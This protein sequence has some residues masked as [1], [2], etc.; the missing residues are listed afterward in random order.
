MTEVITT[1]DKL[2]AP[3]RALGG[4][5][6]WLPERGGIPRVVKVDPGRQMA[7]TGWIGLR[8]NGAYRVRGLQDI[9]LFATLVALGALLLALTSM[10]YR[11]GR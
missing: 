1:E 5:I 9:P 3:I 7:G 11:E 6:D 10:W 2:A 8:A 4:G